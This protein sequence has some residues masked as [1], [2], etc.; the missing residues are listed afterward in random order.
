[1]NEGPFE[2][3][4]V[5]KGM[6]RE[7]NTKYTQIKLMARTGIEFRILQSENEQDATEIQSNV[8]MSPLTYINDQMF[9]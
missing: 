8:L 5:G 3:K 7:K 2:R 1:M 4:Q 9:H 6:N